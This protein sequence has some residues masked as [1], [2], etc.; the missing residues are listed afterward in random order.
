M[1]Q[2]AREVMVNRTTGPNKNDI[3]SAKHDGYVADFGYL[4]ERE[5]DMNE[6]GTR[7]RGRDIVSV[8]GKNNKH[9]PE[10]LLAVARFHVHPLIELSQL[11]D[12]TVVLT[13]P[14]GTRWHFSVPGRALTITDDI[15]MANVSGPRRS[16]QIE[17]A[18]D[19]PE[20]REIRWFLDR[21]A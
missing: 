14:D 9:I 11:N 1:V 6:A 12:E 13:A 19:V 17:V 7:I 16:Q 18:F 15:F 4:H 20:V 5:V 2:G 3:V 21:K 8:A 10:S